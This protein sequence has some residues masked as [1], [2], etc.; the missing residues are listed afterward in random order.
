MDEGFK[1]ADKLWHP[2][3]INILCLDTEVFQANLI[4]DLIQR[5]SLALCLGL[6]YYF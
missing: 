6:W 1:R 4:T 5:F 2:H 3:D